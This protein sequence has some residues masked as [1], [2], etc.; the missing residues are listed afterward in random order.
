M[1]NCCMV[2]LRLFPGHGGLLVDLWL[3]LLVGSGDDMGDSV[4]LGVGAKLGTLGFGGI[5]SSDGT[6]GSDGTLGAGAASVSGSCRRCAEAVC[7]N[8]WSCW[9]EG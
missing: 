3:G 7:S 2:G 6:I 9:F 5:L 1:V 4:V 8:C